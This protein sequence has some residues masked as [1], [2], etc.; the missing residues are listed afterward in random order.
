MQQVDGGV[1]PVAA[2]EPLGQVL[3]RVQSF[4]REV[5]ECRAGEYFCKHFVPFTQAV[6]SNKTVQY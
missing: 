3:L 2:T 1:L 5:L 4:W 6:G